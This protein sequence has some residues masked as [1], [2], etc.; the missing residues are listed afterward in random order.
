[1]RIS[2]AIEPTTYQYSSGYFRTLY[3]VRVD[4]E[5]RRDLQLS[6]QVSYSDSDYQL[7]ANAPAGARSGDQLWQYGLGLSYFIN[8][9][10]FV[11]AAYTHDRLDSN[12]PLDEYDVNRIWLTLSLER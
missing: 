8:R 9:Y 5:L 12:L 11:S 4:H 6:A 2:S 10:M 3:S 1:G 7:T